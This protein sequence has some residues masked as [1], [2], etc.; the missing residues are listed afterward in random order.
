MCE[1]PPLPTYR[2]LV[3]RNKT[4]NA[5]TLAMELYDELPEN[6]GLRKI[7]KEHLCQV[8]LRTAHV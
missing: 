1:L 6:S 3:G 5:V 4:R 2:K 8:R 7:P